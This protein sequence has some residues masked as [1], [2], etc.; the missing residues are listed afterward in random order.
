M[1]YASDPQC[2]VEASLSRTVQSRIIPWD[3][4]CSNMKTSLS[5]RIGHPGKIGRAPLLNLTHN[6]ERLKIGSGPASVRTQ[7]LRTAL[8]LNG[9]GS[10]V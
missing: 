2:A 6:G 3:A 7:Q 10:N 8:V 4:L 1:T 9:L 5:R